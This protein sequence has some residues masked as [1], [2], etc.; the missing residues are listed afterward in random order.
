MSTTMLA[1][2]LHFGTRTFAVEEVPVP[3]PGL[4]EV[5]S[6]SGPPECACPTST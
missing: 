3:V 6:R 5:L 1:G 2:R 4:G